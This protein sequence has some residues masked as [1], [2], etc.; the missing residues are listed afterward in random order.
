MRVIRAED[1]RAVSGGIHPGAEYSLRVVEAFG[2]VFTGD[3]IADFKIAEG[4]KPA[5]SAGACM[6]E[7]AQH[8]LGADFSRNAELG[9]EFKRIKTAGGSRFIH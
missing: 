1:I 5:R 4:S 7:A 9:V 6:R 8:F 2:D 3:I